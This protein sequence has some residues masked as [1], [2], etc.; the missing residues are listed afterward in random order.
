MKKVIVLSGVS[1]SGKSTYAKGLANDSAY[2]TN[3][4]VLIVSADDHFMKD[5]QYS[6]DPSKLSEAHGECF[7]RFLFALDRAGRDGPGGSDTVVVDNTNTTSEEIAPYM[8]AA[9]AFGW[10]AE[11]RTLDIE[12]ADLVFYF[13]RNIHV[14]DI[15]VIERQFRRIVE[16]KLLPWWKHT[17]IRPETP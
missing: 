1:G 8:L 3:G 12:W 15:V 2:A 13:Q 16:R 7:R 14:N 10:E 5:G 17:W 11:I 9:Q 6:F 4:H